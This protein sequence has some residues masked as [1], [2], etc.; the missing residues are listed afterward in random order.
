MK[1]MQMQ[2]IALTDKHKYVGRIVF[3]LQE[4]IAYEVSTMDSEIEQ[5]NI[6]L[7]SGYERR[8]EGLSWEQSDL[9]HLQ[10]TLDDHFFPETEKPNEMDDKGIDFY[11]D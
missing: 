6:H 9:L 1:P 3:N 5:I 8:F 11:Y 2:L 7:S 4:V 10:K